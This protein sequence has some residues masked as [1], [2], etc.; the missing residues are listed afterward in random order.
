MTVSKLSRLR[1]S[2][3]PI[4]SIFLC[5]AKRNP[6]ANSIQFQVDFGGYSLDRNQVAVLE[7]Y[8][9]ELNSAEPWIF[10]SKRN[11]GQRVESINDKVSS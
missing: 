9:L 11:P 3:F 2:F 8:T 4:T 5:V 1:T 7:N 6:R 10:P